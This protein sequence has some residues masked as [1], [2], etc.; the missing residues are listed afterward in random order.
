[1]YR[2]Y[3]LLGSNLGDRE[4]YL[5][6]AVMELMDRLMPDY[7]EVASLA[8]AVNTSEVMETEPIG[9]SCPD[10][11]LNQSFCCLT[12]YEPHQVLEICQEIE[13]ELGR[14]RTGAQY[15]EKGERIY[16]SRC[17][18]IDILSMEKQNGEKW[19]AVVVDTPDLTIPHPQLKTRPFARDLYYRVLKK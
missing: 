14:V 10:K 15:N 18:D 11:F 13:T 5:S 2:V 17:I 12:E 9:F 7:L 8:E 16:Q 1:M 6:D 3:I 19:E 4:Q